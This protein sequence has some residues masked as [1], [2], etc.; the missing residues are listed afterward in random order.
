MSMPT[1]AL[2]NY[3]LR[4][5]QNVYALTKVG[6]VLK[7]EYKANETWEQARQGN[8]STFLQKDLIGRAIWKKKYF[9]QYCS[10]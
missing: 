3:G 5:T 2:L 7:D 10:K 9:Y 6:T 8:K 1:R 4:E